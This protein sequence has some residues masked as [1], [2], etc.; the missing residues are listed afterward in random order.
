MAEKLKSKRKLKLEDL[1][2]DVFLNGTKLIHPAFPAYLKTGER[3]EF[4]LT[5]GKWYWRTKTL[6]KGPFKS[7]SE[8]R[9]DRTKAAERRLEAKR[10]GLPSKPS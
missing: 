5:G 1:I 8:A 10:K 2:E 3:V 7:L 9:D 4:D 6:K